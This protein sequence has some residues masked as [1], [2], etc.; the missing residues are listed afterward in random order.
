MTG[1]NTQNHALEELLFS[2]IDMPDHYKS[3]G[4]D[5]EKQ[6]LFSYAIVNGAGSDKVL[7]NLV[8]YEPEHRILFNEDEAE[9]L[10]DAAPWLVKLVQGERYT[11]WL[12]EECFGERLLLFIQSTE[13]IDLLA[14]HFRHYTKIEFPDKG[15]PGHWIKGFFSFYDPSIFPIWAASLNRDEAFQFFKPV[16]NIGYENARQLRF[17]Y[18]KEKGW[19]Q[20]GFDLDQS[21]RDDLAGESS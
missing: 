17:F 13:S 7:M 10:E 12:M 3:D 6:Q 20:L 9:S 16:S 11:E 18:L 8:G 2:E 5:K 15:K 4:N 19:Q 21:K 1:L 14:E